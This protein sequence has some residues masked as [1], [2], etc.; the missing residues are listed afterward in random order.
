MLINKLSLRIS[1]F[2]QDQSGTTLPEFAL[3]IAL[4]LLILFAILDFGRLGFHWVSAEKAMQRAVRI[5]A[6]RPPVCANVPLFH[7]AGGG[8]YSAGTLCRLET[9]VCSTFSAPAC[10]LN[11][12]E[13]GNQDAVATANEIWNTIAALMPPDTNR[14]NVSLEYSY[15]ANLGFFGGPYVPKIT[16]TLV[17][18]DDECNEDGELYFKFVT[19]L[20]DLA[21]AA[22]AANADSTLPDGCEANTKGI[23]FPNIKATLPAEDMNL[24]M[25]G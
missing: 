2:Q 21:A 14:S 20:S 8:S 5:A 13:S 15:D 7:T 9:G 3:C 24:G 1:R 12:P 11:N 18:G 16:A 25:R 22:G 6:V 17:G 10:T 4:F 23:P 19:P